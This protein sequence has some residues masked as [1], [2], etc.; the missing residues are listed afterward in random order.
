MSKLELTADLKDQVLAICQSMIRVK[1]YSGQ[2][3]GM[4]DVVTMWMNQLGFEDI[5]IDECGNVIGKL[6]AGRLGPIVLYDAHIDTVPEGDVSQWTQ[7]PFGGEIVED[8]I[9]GRGSTDMKGPLAAVMVGLAQAKADGTLRGTA[10]V[11]ASVGEEHLEG[12]ALAGPMKFYIPDLVVI[13]EPS[14]LKLISAQRGRAE[15]AVKTHG[16]SAHASSPQV[17][18]N[19]FRHM[20]RLAV[21]LDK[22][23]PP[24]DDVLGLGILEPTTAIS[25]P[26]PN[27]SVVPYLCTVKYDR[28]LLLGETVDDALAPIQAVIDRMAA[29]DPAFRAEAHIID[30]QF[31]CYTGHVLEQETFAP[32]WQMADDHPFVLKAKQALGT[33]ELHHYSYCTN[34]SYSKGRANKPTI[35]Y[36]PGFEHHAHITD[37]YL[38]L[39]QLFQAVQGYYALGTMEAS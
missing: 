16:K 26:Y 7:D 27:V 11:C 14:A 15:I 5:R 33:D 38:D 10:F 13:C 37:E 34:G 3:D 12:V 21:E 4:A 30:G 20:A 32:A 28:R 1:S 29:A 18:I 6:S 31:T 19:A 35:G 22:I 8:K 17:G 9:Y 2:E 39:E 24:T 25:T 36:G 23:E